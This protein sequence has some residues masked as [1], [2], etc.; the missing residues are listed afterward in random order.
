MTLV[1]GL[2][3]Y[4]QLVLANGHVRCVGEPIAAVFATDAYSAEDIAELVAPEIEPLAPCLDPTA[5]PSE[6]APGRN[7]EAAVITKAY[8]DLDAAFAEAHAVVTLS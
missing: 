6:F 5:T 4:R 8:G 2:E 1:P 7:T 3:A